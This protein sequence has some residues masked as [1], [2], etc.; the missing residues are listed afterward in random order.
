MSAF[1]TSFHRMQDLAADAFF[2]VFLSL[3][4]TPK[5][6]ASYPS[7]SYFAATF[8]S[9]YPH[10]FVRS[11]HLQLLGICLH[12]VHSFFPATCLSSSSL[13]DPSFYRPWRVCDAAGSFAPLSPREAAGGAVLCGGVKKTGG[14]RR[15]GLTTSTTVHLLHGFRSCRPPPPCY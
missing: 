13:P 5:R 7:V 11:E 2:R 9:L 6:P 10:L 1:R 12:S 8:F 14:E 15:W 3:Y 4:C